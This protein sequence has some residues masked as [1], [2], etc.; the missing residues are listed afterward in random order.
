MKKVR[1]SDVAEKVG[2]ST[3]TV[4][5]ALTGNRGVGSELRERIIK[6]ARS[7]GYTP[8]Q[9]RDKGKKEGEALRKIGVL[10]GEN[11]LGQHTTYYWKMYQELAMAAGDR[12]CFAMAE[13]VKKEWMQA[14][15][16]M[17]Q[18]VL[19]HDM[20]GFILIGEMPGPYLE[21]LLGSLPGPVVFLD[22][23]DRGFSR[24]MVLADNYLG[25]YRMTELLF[26]YGFRDIG[27][28]GSVYAAHSIMDRRQGFM[29]AM[30][31]HR[32]QVRP[33]WL[34]EDR[35]A[36]GNM[37]IVLP[38]SLPGA[39][40][41]C[42][43]LTAGILVKE[44]GRL[45]LKVPEDI[46]VAGFDNFLYQDYSDVRITTYDGNMKVMVETALKLLIKRM[47]SP[48]REPETVVVPGRIVQKNSVRH[49]KR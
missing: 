45:G 32:V 17:P 15:G 47:R 46:S 29:R 20:D 24:D 40:V 10:I 22:F 42:C 5:N 49:W 34:L 18:M 21:K 27:F 26:S 41:C 37:E 13:A 9:K 39:F 14:T 2:V 19:E 11:Y 33:E 3:V 30:M 25:M 4:H 6:T 1:L 31:E 36:D 43:D 8:P 35:R 16:E 23:Y 12:Q 38:A 44:L 48:K 7:M 28:V